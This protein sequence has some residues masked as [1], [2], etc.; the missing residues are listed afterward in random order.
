M[1]NPT[2]VQGK[3]EG[4]GLV[5]KAWTFKRRAHPLQSYEEMVR[6]DPSLRQMQTA[7]WWG[8]SVIPMKTG[9]VWA[10][11]SKVSQGIRSSSTLSAAP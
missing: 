7:T 3:V 5:G 9:R 10:K 1:S 11:R 6:S 8:M 4:G 2:Q